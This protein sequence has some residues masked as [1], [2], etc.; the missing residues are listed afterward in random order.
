MFHGKRKELSNPREMLSSRRNLRKCCRAGEKCC[1]VGDIFKFPQRPDNNSGNVVEPTRNV[2]EW[3]TR[4][5]VLN[6]RDMLSILQHS[7]SHANKWKK[8]ALVWQHQPDVQ[9]DTVVCSFDA[10]STSTW[11]FAEKRVLSG[12][13][14]ESSPCKKGGI[15]VL[16]QI[17][18]L[19]L[20]VLLLSAQRIENTC[21]SLP[22]GGSCNLARWRACLGSYDWCVFVCVSDVLFWPCGTGARFLDPSLI[23]R[24][25]V[26]FCG[27][28]S[29]HFRRKHPSNT[30]IL[31]KDNQVGVIISGRGLGNSAVCC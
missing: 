24:A 11:K 22:A 18:S 16:L 25:R 20:Q 10:R 1:R 29:D 19:G 13:I 3:A 8:R 9:F 26:P 5:M 15:S 7:N 2:V 27:G 12:A 28:A 4:G 31:C 30:I 17:C 14:C 23:D 21:S 6:R